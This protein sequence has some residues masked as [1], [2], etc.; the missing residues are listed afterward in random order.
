[1]VNNVFIYADESGNTGQNLWDSHSPFFYQGAIISYGDIESII[2]TEI[3][4]YC[5]EFGVKRLHAFDLGEVKV[6]DVCEKLLSLIKKYNWKFHC[7]TVEKSYLPAI[8]FVDT[9]FDFIDNQV[10]EPDWFLKEQNRHYICLVIDHLMASD[11]LGQEFWN[12]LILQN[13]DE[14]KKV[15]IEIMARNK[16]MGTSDINKIIEKVILS[17]LNDID[18]FTFFAEKGRIKNIYKGHTP[19]MI[20]FHSLLSEAHEFCKQNHSS[21][22]KF[23]HDLSDE[24]KKTMRQDHKSFEKI[25]IQKNNGFFKIIYTDYALGE[26][27]LESSKNSYV[28]QLVDLILWLL[29]RKKD[30]SFISKELKDELQNKVKMFEISRSNSRRLLELNL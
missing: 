2:S 15:C 26:F 28:L 8:K 21:V 24:F 16:K 17:A 23:T 19:N 22:S 4:E 12:C 14:A 18:R 7:T 13:K 11:N 5:Q 1:M 29:Q 10:V 6:V 30:N 27:I 20:G 9:F 25:H 3:E